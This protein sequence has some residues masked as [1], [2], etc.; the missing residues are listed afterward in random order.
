MSCEE[1]AECSVRLQPPGE[2]C[3][4]F[5]FQTRGAS[6]ENGIRLGCSHAVSVLCEGRRIPGRGSLCDTES[7]SDGPEKSD[8]FLSDA[9]MLC[10]LFSLANQLLKDGCVNY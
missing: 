5:N 3:G 9:L 4:D 6:S 8:K 7:P 10:V 1:R 2:Q